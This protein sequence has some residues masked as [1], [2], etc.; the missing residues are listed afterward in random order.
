MLLIG[1][2][3]GLSP[4]IGF[5]LTVPPSNV[6]SHLFG[7]TSVPYQKQGLAK[8]QLKGQTTKST[9]TNI[10]PTYIGDDGVAVPPPTLLRQVEG[11]FLL[12]LPV[13]T[14]ANA[15]CTLS[16][17]TSWPL[18][19]QVG[20]HQL[21]CTAIHIAW[22]FTLVLL[23]MIAVIF[24]A[25]TVFMY[26]R[27]TVDHTGSA[28]AREVMRYVG[29]LALLGSAGLTVLLYLVTS[30]PA[31]V[32]WSSS[33]YLTGL[34]VATPA[35]IAPLWDA[36]RYAKALFK[37]LAVLA[38]Y[39]ILLLGFTY[40][41]LSTAHA[42]DLAPGTQKAAQNDDALIHY[43]LTHGITHF[44]SDYWTCNR[45]IFES[46]ER[47]V[48]SVVDENLQTGLN[49]Y[50]PYYQIVSADPRASYVFTANSVFSRVYAQKNAQNI[51]PYQYST[52]G[53]YVIYQPPGS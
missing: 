37:P 18:S 3:I 40:L 44:Y 32:P 8:K 9:Q 39:G 2:F 12:A 17:K 10:T 43:L 28:D 15:L 35:V 5:Y 1:F 51:Q 38:K 7:S 24:S 16:A 49:R 36:P 25:Q 29:R 47:V 6:S 33:R 46:E 52:F 34:M 13:V 53:G 4:Y 50:V 23:W 45:L 48:C 20:A 22:G 14:G 30:T 31:I 21:Q 26:R 11:T 27:D 42:I 41:L 19:L